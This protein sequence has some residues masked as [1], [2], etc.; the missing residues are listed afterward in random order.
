MSNNV[1]IYPG[2]FDPVTNGHI[3]IVKRAVKMFDKLYI[4]ISNNVS[5]KTLFT[6]EERIEMLEKEFENYDNIEVLVCNSLTVELAKK[7]NAKFLIRGLRA[8]T[9]FEYELQMAH[10]NRKIDSEI[11]TVFLMTS[12]EYSYLSSSLIKEIAKYN[13]DISKFV[14]KHVAIKTIAKLNE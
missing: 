6:L 11:D 8:V 3:D 10:T 2:T 7:I 5:K 4:V 12:T 14:P 1:G 9:D 13:G